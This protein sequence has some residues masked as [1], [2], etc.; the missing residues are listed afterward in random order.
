MK[1][2]VGRLS[3]SDRYD[4]AATI[5]L[6]GWDTA[7]AVFL[8]RGDDYAD[9]LA[10][11]PLAYALEA[12]MLLTQKNRLPDVT[13]EEILRLQA[14][15]VYILGGTGAVSQGVEN[16]LSAMGLRIIR[17]SGNNR[18]ATAAA[19]ARELAVHTVPEKVVLAYGQDYPDALAAAAYAAVAGYPILLVQKD[20]L[21]EPTEGVINELN[22]TE[23][24]IVGGTAVISEELQNSLPVTHRISGRTRYDTAVELAKYFKPASELVFLATGRNFA[25][26]VTGGVLA[27]ATGAGM[28]L[29]ER[30]HVPQGVQ[31]Y[32]DSNPPSEIIAFGGASAIRDSTILK[33]A[34]LEVRGNTPG[35]LA[36]NGRVANSEG[37]VYF[38]EPNNLE[39]Y[40]M[41]ED[42]SKIEL[43]GGEALCDLNV[44][45]DWIYYH[46]KQRRVARMRTDGSFSEVLTAE[47]GYFINVMDNWIYYTNLHNICRMRLDGSGQEVLLEPEFSSTRF[48]NLNVSGGYVYYSVYQQ[49]PIYQHWIERMN[50][51]TGETEVL[52]YDM[53]RFFVDGQWIYYL[54]DYSE[55]QG[56]YR[57]QLN[58]EGIEPLLLCGDT[59]RPDRI[60]IHDGWIYYLVTETNY[61]LGYM[62]DNL[63]RM[64][65]DG[66]NVEMMCFAHSGASMSFFYSTNFWLYFGAYID[67]DEGTLEGLFRMSPDGSIIQQIF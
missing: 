56:I 66:S 51:E 12:P 23:F 24:L 35:N 20:A 14:T 13:K 48:L 4:T 15:S 22:V 40:R 1:T 58:G 8:A 64:Q 53:F 31:D 11:V 34:R 44:V 38:I 49:E 21:T 29:V 9:A 37:W 16:E 57:S 52:Q 2:Y 55:N 3:G 30:E 26:A 60:N 42:G 33:A 5:S 39:I 19:V 65:T 67:T 62:T 63:Y 54:T 32:L 18:Y 45:D 59:R 41:H 61:E 46:D 43:L 17:I 28:L 6:V 36:N 50:I 47:Q 25:D 7:E 10:G 27:A